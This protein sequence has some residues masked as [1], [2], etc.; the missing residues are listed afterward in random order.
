VA[1]LGGVDPVGR[2]VVPAG[3]VAERL[4][5]ARPRRRVGPGNQ[6]LRLQVERRPH[7]AGIDPAALSG[8]LLA[9][10]RRQDA[11]GE[12]GGTVMIDHRGAGRTRAGR[13]LPG[14]GHHAE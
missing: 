11:H 1:V 7:Q 2:R 9:H 13:R 10:D 12:Q 6:R 8:T 14:D 5:Y 3:D 4:R